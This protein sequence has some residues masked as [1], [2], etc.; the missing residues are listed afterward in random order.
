MQSSK[1]FNLMA[2]KYIDPQVTYETQQTTFKILL[3][4]CPIKCAAVSSTLTF[5]LSLTQP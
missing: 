5:L 3:N 4:L 1:I 2:R